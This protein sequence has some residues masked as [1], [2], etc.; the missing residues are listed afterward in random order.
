MLRTMLGAV[1]LDART[2]TLGE[3][4]ARVPLRPGHGRTEFPAHAVQLAPWNCRLC[5][6]KT[7]DNEYARKHVDEE[8]GG[9]LLHRG[10]WFYF[11]LEEGWCAVPGGEEAR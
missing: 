9:E 11:E 7:T 3:E 8:H 5:D 2:T 1:S 10:R 6:Y 4:K